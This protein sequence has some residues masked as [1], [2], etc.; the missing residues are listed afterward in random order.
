M[1]AKGPQDRPGWDEI[2]EVIAS[3]TAGEDDGSP[4]RQVVEQ[5]LARH[6]R[7]E[8]ERLQGERRQ[9]Q[10]EHLERLYR[11][12]FEQ[13]VGRFD[14]IV[15]EFNAEFQHGEIRRRSTMLDIDYDLPGSPPIS[16]RLFHRRETGRQV[17]GGELIGGAVLAVEG[18]ASANLLLVR[19]GPNDL[20]GRWIGCLVAVSALVDRTRALSHLTSVPPAVPFGFRTEIDFYEHMIYAGGGMHI[21]TY[22]LTSDLDALFRELLNAAFVR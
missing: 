11:A 8:R 2:I 15:A 4:T 17:S 22:E 5:A 1:T 14:R 16:I 13:V 9:G 7:L 18:G 21:F 6:E 12:S 19:E 10:S 3:S 20:Y